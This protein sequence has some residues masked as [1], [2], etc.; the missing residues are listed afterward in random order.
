[1]SK[2]HLLVL[3]TRQ[4]VAIVS[5]AADRRFQERASMLRRSVV[6]MAMA[7]ALLARVGD[8]QTVGIAQIS[9]VVSD[10]SG[11][12][13]PGVEVEVTQTAT[14][15]TRLAITGARGEYVLPNLPVGHYRLEAKLQGLSTYSPTGITSTV[16]SNPVVN[17]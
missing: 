9:G 16:V 15:A 17:V 7:L 10:Q 4:V 12:A 8:A 6:P 3:T 11:A 5:D 14:G 1:A 2:G 13:L